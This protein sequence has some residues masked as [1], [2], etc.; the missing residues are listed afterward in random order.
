MVRI[1]VVGYGYWGPNIVRNI[2]RLPNATVAWV[3]DINPKILHEIPFSY[4]TIKTTNSFRDL[5]HDPSLDAVIIATPT[6]T[7]FPLA[8]QAILAGK[9]VL[10]EK[11]MT[12][13][14]KEGKKLVAIAKRKKKILMVDHTFIYTQAIV[15]LKS[16]IESGQLG[17]VF[18]ID[19]VRM[20]LGILQKDVNVIYDLATHDFSIMDY[21]FNQMPK[22]MTATGIAHKKLKQETVAH[23]GVTYK[24]DLFV[25]CHVSW[26]SPIKIRR[27][28]FVGTKKMLTYDDVDPSEKLKIYDKGISF[29]KDPKQSLQLRIGYRSGSAVIPHIT[30]EEGLFG[31]VKEFVNAIEKNRRPLTD[32]AMGLRVVRCLEAATTSLRAKGK[33]VTL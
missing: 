5:L 6:S 33:L 10:V 13:T 12:P 4:P 7:H 23:L 24:N 29:I 19:S 3:C 16:I 26:L 9:H 31:M 1:G 18:Y 17:H 32:G 25:H 11:P 27:M 22:T 20:N 2:S 14:V 8:Q 28:I 21:L 15:K 30:I